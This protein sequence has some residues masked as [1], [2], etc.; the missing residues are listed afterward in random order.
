VQPALQNWQIRIKQGVTAVKTG[1]DADAVAAFRQ[2][3]ALHASDPIPH[4]Y[5][6]GALARRFTPEAIPRLNP[7]MGEEAE[8]EFERALELDPKSW[9]AL[10]MLGQ[11]MRQQGRFPE[12]RTWYG[13]TLDLDTTNADIC[14]LLGGMSWTQLRRNGTPNTALI[15]EGISELNKAL[16][17]DPRHVA[18]MQYG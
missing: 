9:P 5:L 12:A 18:A 17:L 3:V 4:L 10:V 6:A 15:D 7:E 16:T 2:A 8:R 13:R 1:R 14:C 11:L